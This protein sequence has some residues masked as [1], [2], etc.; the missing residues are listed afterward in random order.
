MRRPGCPHITA[1]HGTH[2]FPRN[3]QS[4]LVLASDL[5]YNLDTTPEVL[6]SSRIRAQ[7]FRRTIPTIHISPSDLPRPSLPQ[8]ITAP[9]NI[10]PSTDRK[11]TSRL[12]A[13]AAGR[14]HI[15]VRCLA[16]AR[17]ATAAQ[18]QLLHTDSPS[19]RAPC[20]A[21]ILM[22]STAWRSSVSSSSSSFP[23]PSSLRFDIPLDLD[24]CP[25]STTES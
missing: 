19:S 7:L 24:P 8:P 2:R 16:A 5:L 23:I 21:R 25:S 12:Q 10:F 20:S 18:C 9:K 17:Y 22:P 1:R 3:G 15:A 14:R 11:T 4:W 6:A 13:P